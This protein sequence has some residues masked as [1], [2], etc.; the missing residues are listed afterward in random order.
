MTKTA[1]NWL[2]HLLNATILVIALAG[3]LRLLGV[4]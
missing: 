3:V 2:A 1:K 4:I